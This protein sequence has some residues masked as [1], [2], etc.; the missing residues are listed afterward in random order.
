MR[1]SIFDDKKSL[2]E[3]IYS[4]KV[5]FFLVFALGISLDEGAGNQPSKY[6]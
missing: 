3:E 1:N 6:T 2:Q 5:I 4:Q